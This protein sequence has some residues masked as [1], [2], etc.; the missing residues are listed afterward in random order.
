MKI[1][2]NSYFLIQ[3]TKVPRILVLFFNYFLHTCT[4]PVELFNKGLFSKG[5]FNTRVA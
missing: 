4:N 5:L 1:K 3:L 2:I